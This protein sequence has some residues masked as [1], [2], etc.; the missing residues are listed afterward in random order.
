MNETTDGLTAQTVDELTDAIDDV[1]AH[2]L[3]EVAAAATIGAAVIGAGGAALAA[4]HGSNPTPGPKTPAIVQQALD[5]SRQL[6]NDAADGA[7]QLGQSAKSDAQL[8][9]GHTLTAVH[10]AVDPTVHQV[11]GTVHGV[12]TAVTSIAQDVSSF[13]SQTAGSAIHT[14][15]TTA[16]NAEALATKTAGGAVT[17][18]T[19]TAGKTIDSASQIAVDKVDRVNTTVRGVRG[20]AINLVSATQDKVNRGWNLSFD[21]LG[22]KVSIGGNMLTPT[23]TLSIVNAKGHTLATAKIGHGTCSI[24]LSAIGQDKTVTVQ[25]SGDNLYAPTTLQWHTPVGF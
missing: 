4:G 5:D 23:G 8:V 16:G 2:G 24:H 3:R 18:A 12:A 13:A 6:A 15:G 21:V 22:E 10:S 7:G 9:A 17:T 11:S 14:A 1:E 20:A 19:Q 25:Y